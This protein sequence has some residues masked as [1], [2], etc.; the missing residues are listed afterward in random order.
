MFRAIKSKDMDMNPMAHP[1][2]DNNV[3]LSFFFM[4]FI[5]FGAFFI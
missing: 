4:F 1:P 5:I 2:Y 3:Y